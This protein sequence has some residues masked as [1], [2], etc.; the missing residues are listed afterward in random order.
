MSANNDDTKGVVDIQ[1]Y[2]KKME[3]LLIEKDNRCQVLE[4]NLIS[5]MS[6]RQITEQTLYE[7]EVNLKKCEENLRQMQLFLQERDLEI[8]T[9][10]Q[11]LSHFMERNIND[12]LPLSPVTVTVTNNTPPSSK[13]PVHTSPDSD[14]WRRSRIA[15]ELEY[16]DLINE[17][18]SNLSNL[19]VIMT[20]QYELLRAADI[21]ITSLSNNLHDCQLHELTFD[22]KIRRLE[23]V[24][25]E[26]QS[27]SDGQCELKI[28]EQEREIQ[29][30]QC[31]L[32]I[33]R[34][35]SWTVGG[36]SE[37]ELYELNAQ[38]TATQLEVQDLKSKL[39]KDSSDGRR[40]KGLG[41]GLGLGLGEMDVHGHHHGTGR[42]DIDTGYA[43]LD[44]DAIIRRSGPYLEILHDLEVTLAELEQERGWRLEAE[45]VAVRADAERKHTFFKSSEKRKVRH[46]LEKYGSFW[47][48]YAMI[49]G[50]CCWSDYAMIYGPFCWSD[51]TMI[52]GPCWTGLKNKNPSNTKITLEQLSLAKWSNYHSPTAS[53]GFPHDKFKGNTRITGSFALLLS[54]G[55]RFLQHSG[56]SGFLIS[57][58]PVPPSSKKGAHQQYAPFSLSLIT[59]F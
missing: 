48:D 16:L 2:I 3:N 6:S 17:N 24:I 30:L 28:A 51:Y 45:E 40:R 59:L 25:A 43:G 13:I 21:T 56:D 36:N 47:S 12:S 7:T 18:N 29:S 57:T 41:L 4:R 22:E 15:L 54:F 33:L 26:L 39:E 20:A 1:K 44:D 42:I 11:K 27:Q 53:M 52:Y 34:K 46:P 8:G 23:D 37:G 10:K 35:I 31:K 49:Y 38:L 9:L 50:P 19:Y 5:T 55:D 58:F 14:Q 32:D